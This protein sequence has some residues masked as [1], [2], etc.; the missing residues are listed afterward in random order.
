MVAAVASEMPDP[1]CMPCKGSWRSKSLACHRLARDESSRPARRGHRPSAPLC[2]PDDFPSTPNAAGRE[3]GERTWE[4]SVCLGDAVHALSADLK[5][6][7]NF[8]GANDGLPHSAVMLLLSS[9]NSK[10]GSSTHTSRATF[11]TQLRA[12]RREAGRFEPG[13]TGLVGHPFI[14]STSSLSCSVFTHGL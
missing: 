14:A 5:K 2:P 9:V 6:I 4:I 7:P 8:L 12:T 10:R 3:Y 1:P 11:G 13:S